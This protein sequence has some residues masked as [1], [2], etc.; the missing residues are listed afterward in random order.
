MGG[1]GLLRGIFAD[2]R[3]HPDCALLIADRAWML[4]HHALQFVHVESAQSYSPPVTQRAPA[5]G[6]LC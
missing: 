3:S 4:A 5:V 2:S 1:G 6:R